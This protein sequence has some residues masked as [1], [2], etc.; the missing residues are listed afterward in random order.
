MY[1][2]GDVAFV[3]EPAVGPVGDHVDVAG[4]V[5]MGDT[6]EHVADG[7]DDFWLATLGCHTE[8]YYCGN[9][10]RAQCLLRPKDTSFSRSGRVCGPGGKGV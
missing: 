3:A 2:C 9:G 4:Y 5:F 6:A 7:R 8:Q 1:H 10:S